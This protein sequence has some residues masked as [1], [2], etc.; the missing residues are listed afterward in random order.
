MAN[1]S[2]IQIEFIECEARTENTKNIIDFE[3]A[4]LIPTNTQHAHA[5]NIHLPNELNNRWCVCYKC[6]EHLSTKTIMHRKMI[7]TTQHSTTD[8]RT[9]GSK[10]NMQK[11]QNREDENE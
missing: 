1:K 9:N 5:N 2:H 4:Q 7:H 11:K 6:D 3:R 10:Q 8:Q